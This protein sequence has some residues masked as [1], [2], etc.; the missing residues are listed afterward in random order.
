M[1]QIEFIFIIIIIIFI[2]GNLYLNLIVIIL[3]IYIINILLLL[4]IYFNHILIY[5]YIYIFLVA[6]IIILRESYWSS[7]S[8]TILTVNEY[9]RVCVL[10]LRSYIHYTWSWSHQQSIGI[11]GSPAA[12]PWQVDISGDVPSPGT[13][14]TS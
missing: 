11:R 3:R 4:L 10:I 9:H 14:P 6:I 5:L 13:S 1:R 2:I 8:D 12:S 7:N